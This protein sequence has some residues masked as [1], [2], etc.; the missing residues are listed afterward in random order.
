M[1]DPNLLCI[2]LHLSTSSIFRRVQTSPV[3]LLCNKAHP[4]LLL[5]VQTFIILVLCALTSS[6]VLVYDQGY[7]SYSGLRQAQFFNFVT[8]YASSPLTLGSEKYD[9]VQT[10]YVNIFPNV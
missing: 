2:T 1:L 10:Y 7:V 8:I 5:C 9:C 4:A 3:I 6:D